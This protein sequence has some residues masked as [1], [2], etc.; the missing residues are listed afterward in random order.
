MNHASDYDARVAALTFIDE[1]VKRLADGLRSRGV[2]DDTLFLVVSDHGP[3]SGRPGMGEVRDASV[4]ERSVNVPFVMMGPQL[5]GAGLR[6][7]L[8]TSHLDIAPTVLALTGVAVPNTMK[9]RNLVADTSERMVIMATRPPL[10]QIGV[11]AGPM[12]LVYW[13]ENELTELFDLSVD[14][15]E[16]DDLSKTRREVG[17][18]MLDVARRWPAHSANLIENY[19]PIRNSDGKVCVPPARGAAQ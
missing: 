15:D 11:R 2:L 5:P 6:S 10:S 4:Y 13:Q 8:V 19:V 3:G 7:T 14:P 9:G 17:K 16:R 18:S 1:S 12:K